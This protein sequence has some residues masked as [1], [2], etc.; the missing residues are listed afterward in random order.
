MSSSPSEGQ[1]STSDN[2][3]ICKLGTYTMSLAY[4]Y[5]QIIDPLNQGYQ[6]LSGQ[7]AEDS[8]VMTGN[9]NGG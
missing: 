9:G 4:R 2:I 1:E 8:K 7:V 6:R 3:L 5:G